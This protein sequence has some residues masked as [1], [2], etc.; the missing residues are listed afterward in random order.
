VSDPTELELAATVVGYASRL[1]GT[2]EQVHELL[3]ALPA[4]NDALQ[5]IGLVRAEQAD[6]SSWTSEL[7]TVPSPYRQPSS[8][9]ILCRFVKPTHT[10]T[11]RTQ[12]SERT[13]SA[14]R[15]LSE[16]SAYQCAGLHS[17]PRLSQPQVLGRSDQAASPLSKLGPCPAVDTT[18]LPAAAILERA[19]FVK[20][21]KHGR[22]VRKFLLVQTNKSMQHGF[23]PFALFSTDYSPGRAEPL[24]TSLSVAGS[25]ERAEEQVAA[26]RDANIKRGWES[27]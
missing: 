18:R 2:T 24:K 16:A 19:V 9:G 23:S 17:V 25:R 22:C 13:Q 4:D 14:M 7:E 26:W 8:D 15:L 12:C 10:V 3:L 6:A 27:A 1:V 21:S 11:L 5:V 20:D